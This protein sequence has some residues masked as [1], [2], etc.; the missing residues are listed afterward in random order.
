MTKSSRVKSSRI[1]LPR[2]K[3]RLSDSTALS[4]SGLNVVVS[5]ALLP[6]SAAP[7]RRSAYEKQP[8]E[9]VYVNR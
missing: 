3:R 2:V 5:A 8:G 1:C 9:Q 4:S 7:Q 6:N